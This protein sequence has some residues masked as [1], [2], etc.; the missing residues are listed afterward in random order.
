MTITPEQLNPKSAETKLELKRLCLGLYF[1]M[2]I[3]HDIQ[4]IPLPKK[5][6]YY[7]ATKNPKEKE[8]LWGIEPVIH[9]KERVKTSDILFLNQI[10]FNIVKYN[11]QQKATGKPN[12]RQ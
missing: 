2:C 9:L 8:K 7:D 1:D 5:C 3:R 11:N 4:K 10:I 12:E 6:M